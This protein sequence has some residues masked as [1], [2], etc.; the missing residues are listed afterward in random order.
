M[1][2]RQ[3]AAR[4]RRERSDARAVAADGGAASSRRPSDDRLRQG[5][6][7]GR[8]VLPGGD[9]GRALLPRPHVRPQ[10][11]PQPRSRPV[12]ALQGPRGPDPVRRP[13]GARRHSPGRDGPREDR[14][15]HAAGPSRHGTDAWHRS[16]DRLPG[17][18]TLH[19]RG[20]GPGAPAGPT[21]E[22]GLRDHRRRGA[23]RRPALGSGD[24]GRRLSGRQPHRHRG[25]QP[26]P[27][28]R[29]HN[30]GPAKPFYRRQIRR[31]SAG[32]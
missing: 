31:A 4:S 24:G 16:G 19:R 7:S 2:G 18:G 30:G 15:G 3:T 27:G 21:T 17:P 23:F 13:G 9:R 20:D 6:A 1:Q 26:D 32:A 22:P 25:P 28:H 12:S 29:P 10:G 5:R 8:L 11:Y 14:G